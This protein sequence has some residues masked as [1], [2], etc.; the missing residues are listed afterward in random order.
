MDVG[1]IMRRESRGLA[2]S[3]VNADMGDDPLL[4]GK[5][6][7]VASAALLC[8][9]ILVTASGALLFDTLSDLLSLFMLASVGLRARVCLVSA[10]APITEG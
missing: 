7:R 1:L 8:A 2:E 4:S 3:G 6:V 10:I 5:S 9:S